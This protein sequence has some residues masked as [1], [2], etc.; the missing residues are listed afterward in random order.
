MHRNHPAGAMVRPA[1]ALALA[2]ALLPACSDGPTRPAPREFSIGAPEKVVTFQAQALGIQGSYDLDVSE[3]GVVVGRKRSPAGESAFRWSRSGGEQDLGSLGGTKYTTALGINAGGEVVGSS[4]PAG[5]ENRV[6]FLRSPSGALQAIGPAGTYSFAHDVSDAGVV[7]G[8][9]NL[10][11]ATRAFRWTSTAGL[12][13]LQDLGGGF[14]VAYAVNQQGMAVGTSNHASTTTSEPVVW[15]PSGEV[16]R[17]PTLGPIYG[18][19]FD[20]NRAGQ[21]VGVSANAAGKRRAVLWEAGGVRDLGTLGGEESDAWGINDRG[22]VVGGSRTA[23]GAWHAFYW[24]EERGMIDLGKLPD[25]DFSAA[26]KINDAGQ[27]VGLSG[28]KTG[29]WVTLWEI[30]RGTS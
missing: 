25:T 4:T 9:V 21:A 29:G 16:R 11:G 20:A 10:Q 26:V 24:S 13:V 27:I 18:V 6:A 8:S 30:D 22:E 15:S 23:D 7:V 5:A 1:A 3:A 12:Q 28:G 19:A 2:A 17:L 14:S